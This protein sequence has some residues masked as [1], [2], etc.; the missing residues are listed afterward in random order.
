MVQRLKTI[1]HS[2]VAKLCCN[3]TNFSEILILLIYNYL[4]FGIQCRK[5]C[6]FPSK[7]IGKLSRLRHC[8]F[9]LVAHARG[10]HNKY[11]KYNKYNN[12]TV[13]TATT[14]TA[15]AKHNYNNIMMVMAMRV[16]YTL[17]AS[18]I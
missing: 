3:H 11:N 18:Q 7:A 13:T 12:N 4:I 10:W 14:M 2:K 9:E 15:N 5:E 6:K 8:L 16:K 17:K 1:A